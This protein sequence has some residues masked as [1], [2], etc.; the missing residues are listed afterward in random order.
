LFEKGY[1][2]EEVTKVS[3]LRNLNILWEVYT[4]VFPHKRHD[5]FD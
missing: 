1:N 5:K 4:E 3:G 2:I